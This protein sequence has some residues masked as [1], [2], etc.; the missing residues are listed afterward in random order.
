[1]PLTALY[2]AAF[3]FQQLSGIDAAIDWH[4]RELARLRAARAEL[5]APQSGGDSGVDIEELRRKLAIAEA[6]VDFYADPVNWVESRS[7]KPSVAGKDK[8]VIARKAL[9]DMD[10]GDGDGEGDGE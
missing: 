1:M 7:G 2:G 3:K 6:A 5:D 8:G 9:T 10:D 4:E